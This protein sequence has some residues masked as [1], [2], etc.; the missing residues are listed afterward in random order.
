[1]ANFRDNK[2]LVRAAL[3][4]DAWADAVAALDVPPLALINV[5][6]ACLPQG[7]PTS[8]RAAKLLGGLVAGLAA[9][10]VTVEQARIFVRRLLWHMNEESGNIGWG[11]PEALGEILAADRGLAEHFHRVLIS[12]ILHTPT[13]NDNFCD[14]PVIRLACYGAVR[15]LV[16][17]WPDLGELAR[18]A[19]ADGAVNDPDAPCRAAAAEALTLLER[20]QSQSATE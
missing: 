17:T 13:G 12:Y 7:T 3:E 18:T 6:L 4:Q 19:L 10:Y 1:M 16:E 11:V 20:L 14:Q 2:A 15:R 5:L 8:E 9:S